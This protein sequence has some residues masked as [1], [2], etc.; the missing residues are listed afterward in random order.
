MTL[1][2]RN[3]FFKAGI[4]FC[5]ICTVLILA[6][7][8][9]LFPVYETMGENSRRPA[10][11]FQVLVLSKL[12]QPHYFAVH[13]SLILS[14]LFSLV[15]I[16]MILAFFEQTSAPE[17]P[18]IAI[19]TI[20]FS[21][22]IIRLILPL[23]LLYDFPSFYLILASRVLLFARYFS[24]FSLFAASVC[25]AGLEIQKT[26]TIIIVVLIATLVVTFGVPIDAQS[27]DTSLNMINGYTSM[28]KLIEGVAFFITVISFFIAVNV[29]G[30]KEYGHIGLG[31]LLALI[32]RYFLL[33]VDNWAGPAAGIVFVSAGV[34]FV[35]SKLHKIHL[36]L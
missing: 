21:F 24:I 13:A 23:R 30:S 29:R 25:A 1:A 14:V 28:F 15:G 34:W 3:A 17:I 33:N 5:A 4:A 16:I 6:A 36:W 19:F 10:D 18:Y 12:L 31:V 27:W 7:S 2:E 35:C 8:F 9:L 22:E 11:F 20:S 32:G 26:R